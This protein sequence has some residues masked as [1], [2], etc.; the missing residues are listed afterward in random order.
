MR[1]G[2]AVAGFLLAGTLQ[3]A[4][5]PRSG[6]AQ[7]PRVTVSLDRNRAAVG[8]TV[9]L[10]VEVET[11]GNTPVQIADPS[12]T[13]L[14]LRD[15]REVSQVSVRDTTVSRRTRRVLV[16]RAVRA[17]TAVIG[18]ARV[19][20][21]KAVVATE[22][23]TLEISGSRQPAELAPEI[24]NLIALA[25]SPPLGSEVAVLLIPSRRSLRVGEQLD[26][27]TLAWF[28]R[29]VR[30]R[31]R[32]PPT[33]AAPK[34]TGLWSY[35]YASPAGVVA[36]RKLGDAWYDAFADIRSAFPLQP[37]LLSI[38]GAGVAYTF[39]L[40]YAFLTREV[41]HEVQSDT[42]VV[43]VTALPE[44]GRPSGWTGAIGA[45]LSLSVNPT[46]YE[47]SA[48]E[49]RT[50]KVE[51]RGEGNVVLWPEPTII[52]PVG[53]R[54]YPGAV[55]FEWERRGSII[56]GSKTFSY[57]LVADSAGSFRIPGPRY[58]YFDFKSGRYVDLTTLPLEISVRPSDRG[59]RVPVAL[60]PL[61]EPSRGG[62][63]T[64]TRWPAATWAVVVVLPPLVV[65][66][67]ALGRRQR[68]RGVRRLPKK[69]P[70][71]PFGKLE[72]ELRSELL[73]LVPR[74]AEGDAAELG[75]A[76]RAVGLEPPVAAQVARVRDRLRQQV[77][78]PPGL[79]DPEEV[80]AEVEEVLAVLARGRWPHSD[81]GATLGVFWV[82]CLA[83]AARPIWGQEL[84]PEE[85]Y[86]AGAV[87]AAADSFAARAQ[88]EPRAVQHW[89][90]LGCAW[91]AMGAR[92][93]ARV[94]WLRAAR[95]APRDAAVR[96]ALAL[97]SGGDP[98]RDRL[99]RVAPF[100]PDELLLGAGLLWF[101]GWVL[102]LAGVA[103]ARVK[104]RMW[105]S[106]VLGLAL[107]LGIAGWSTDARYRQ[108]VA[109]ALSE[110]PLREAPYGSAPVRHRLEEGKA[111]L[112]ELVRGGWLLV[113]RDEGGVSGWVRSDEVIRL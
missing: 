38:A 98:G 111:V 96:R 68:P 41:T 60:L 61:M 99:V 104:T 105:G 43:E 85:L 21:G 75:A 54:V 83:G 45:G 4:V 82:L 28:R 79:G 23:L 63:P 2:S 3:I 90:N 101:A 102:V 86:R 89:Y 59:E 33:F 50:V 77:F 58:P 53:L 84:A 71:E 16:L 107:W 12:L 64:A 13:G 100:T 81:L 56:G 108:P 32:A 8:D 69:S 22:S 19:R 6:A 80:R 67:V 37:G 14:V 94:A 70:S 29:D 30:E 76:L 27:L 95:L 47:L 44:V 49:A 97:V 57:V 17:G 103:R 15:V 11:A 91:Y 39:P 46:E 40:S 24:A 1:R 110:L 25:P 112:V 88:A 5:F 93:K 48:G 9:L 34:L 35:S 7:E 113:R 73:R 92:T 36:S 51:V 109:L 18:P 74:A 66:G 72:L 10:T 87:A 52:W 31:L 106:A 42:A 62:M 26:L 55:E 78:G 65:S 20:Q